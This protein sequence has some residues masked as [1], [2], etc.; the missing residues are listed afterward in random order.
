MK[1]RFKLINI[2]KTYN[3]NGK[4]NKILDNLNLNIYD[5]LVNAIIGNSGEGKS[6]IAKL[7]MQ[8]DD[9]CSGEIFYKSKNIKEY[10]IKIFRWENQIVFQNP[11]EA[12]NP[13]F[14]IKKIIEEPMI[15]RGIEKN[16]RNERIEELMDLIKLPLATLKRKPH[17]VSGG[18]LQRIVLARALSIE[19]EFL[20]LDEPFSSLDEITAYELVKE[21]KRIF[22]ELKIGVFYI[23]HNMERVLFLSDQINI[24]KNK[25]IIVSEQKENLTKT[26]ILK[27]INK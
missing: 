8:I 27:F 10:N 7:I 4:K 21:F 16:K 5:S 2:S 19:P 13:Y 1:I 23:S 17:E 6:T 3:K 25:K 18:Q 22:N 15:V 9:F 24:L 12:V 20:V 11:F 26:E 14:K